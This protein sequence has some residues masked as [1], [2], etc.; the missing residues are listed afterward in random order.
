MKEILTDDDIAS[1]MLVVDEFV[2]RKLDYRWDKSIGG[3]KTALSIYTVLSVALKYSSV[4][5]KALTKNIYKEIDT[6][7]KI[8]KGKMFD[9]EMLNK[10]LENGEIDY[11]K[12]KNEKNRCFHHPGMHGTDIYR[13]R[14]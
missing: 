12:L 1:A 5:V 6:Y 9:L 14:R 11:E 10:F 13:L 2:R 4:N 7:I 3:L 8:I